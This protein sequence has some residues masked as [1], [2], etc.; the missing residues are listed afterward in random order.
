MQHSGRQAAF[1]ERWAEIEDLDRASALLNWDQ[2]THMPAKGQVARG[3]ALATLAGLR[4]GKLVSKE[5]EGALVALE[6]E[7]PPGSEAAAQARTARREIAR[8]VLTPAALAKRQAEAASR[9][10]AAW[11]AARKAADFAL[12]EP[13]LL[14]LVAL[15]REQGA[16]LAP[17]TTSKRPYD[18]LLDE[19]EPGATEAE[20]VPLFAD[21]SAALSP[22]VKAVA[23]S[24]V[25]IDEDVLRGDYPE[26]AQLDFG[27]FVAARM[28]F[29]FEAGR[30]DA[31]PHPFCSAFDPRDV[32]LTWRWQVDDFRPGLYGIMHEAGHGLYEQGLP[33][34]WSRTPLGHAASLG[35]HES[36]SRLWEN[37]V[38]RSH[39]FWRWALPHFHERFPKQRHLRGEEIVRALHVV[40]PS[41]IRVE[42]DEATYNLHVAARFGL[43]RAL[44]AGELEVADLPGAW[45][46]AYGE[47]LGIR[48]PSAAAGVLQ[49]IHWAMGAFGYFPTYALG[50]LINAQLFRAA[51]A[52]LGDLDQAMARGELAPL[53]AWLRERVH[54]HGRRLEAA[55]VV[56][57]ATG[58][59]LAA[60]DFLAHIES[61]VE[62]N[63][64]I[65]VPRAHAAK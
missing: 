39:A 51:Q 36:Q 5:L 6:E 47:L 20:L 56:R 46:E 22:I 30:I 42:A 1:F 38:G 58:R 62:E 53:L 52:E 57:R 31:A 23:E 21:L 45:D 11:Q 40:R 9:G 32:R 64:G 25:V 13:H 10:L 17:L 61:R 28:G 54:R 50:N 7:A 18:A 4:H 14:E 16:C 35:L 3:Q 65:R 33:G 43:E 15:A 24:G 59:P 55:E 63:Y 27:R 44:F 37:L 2:E 48:A 49:D 29:D 19:Y 26:A 34:S 60:D 41:L 12:F 8:A